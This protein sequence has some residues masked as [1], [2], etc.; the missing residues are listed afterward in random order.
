ML[1]SMRSHAQSW[2]A[3]IILGGIVLSFALWGIGDYFLGSRIQTVA[4]IDGEPIPDSAFYLAYERQLNAYRALLGKQFSKDMMERLGVKEETLQTLINRRL[5]LAEAEGMG[6]VVPQTALLSRI[7]SNP[8]FQTAGKFDPNRYQI[9]TRNMGFKSPIDY[10]HQIRLDLLADALQRALF[11]SAMVDEE[12]VRARFRHDYERRVIGAI[13]VDPLNLMEGLDISLDEAKAYYEAHKQAYQ[14]P[15]RVRFHVV[16]IDPK[17]IEREISPSEAEIRAAYEEQKN[18]LRQP[19]RRRIAHILFRVKTG[20]ASSRKAALEKA[21][22]VFALLQKGEDF[23][24]LARRYSDDKAT[25][26]K[27]GDMGYITRG[28]LS[29][30]LEDAAFAL[31]K[32]EISDILE[33]KHGFHLLKI[34]DVQASTV[35]PLAEVRDQIVAELKRAKASEEAFRL[36]QDLDDAL[37]REESLK[38]AAESLNLKVIEKGPL[39][40][41]EALADPQ[42]ASDPRLLQIVFTSQPEDPVE[43]IEL[44]DGRFAAVQVLERTNPEVLPFAEVSERVYADAKKEKARK[45][46]QRLAETLRKEA[47][48]EELEKLAQKY[49]QP[50][51]L[52]KPVRINGT[53]DD[54]T[55][56][57]NAVLNAAFATEEGEV[58][59]NVVEIPQG[60]AVIKVLNILPPEERLDSLRS[61]LEETL[62]KEH[63]AVRFARWM[64]S[65]RDKHE[66]VIHRKVLERF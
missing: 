4:E 42:L 32:G 15:L 48:Q 66:V 17:S 58:A 36:S 47:A 25:A 37:G 61:T 11:E 3:K 16:L 51:Y 53:G 1:E 64:A 56:L 38:A 62:R 49:G 28:R 63:G 59:G 45:K 31:K 14:S 21:K 30:S 39:S 20:D 35:P 50:L 6:L 43:I 41:N 52:S 24:E 54:A 5:L 7:Q 60:F 33:D 34:I 18:A 13:V 26:L 8:S 40:R 9:L 44:D 10:E 27:G 22:R 2:I 57:T 19:E 12:E 46:A 55:W 65:I 29:P 23:A